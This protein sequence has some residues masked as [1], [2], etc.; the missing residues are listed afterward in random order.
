MSYF[1]ATVDSV[2][3]NLP[4]GNIFRVYFLSLART[5]IMSE[6]YYLNRTS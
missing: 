3:E 5:I 1:S 6:L 4:G 2:T